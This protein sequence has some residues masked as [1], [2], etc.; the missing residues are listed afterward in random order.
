MGRELQKKKRRSLR[1]PVRPKKPAKK[2]LN[3]RGN[4]IVAK[5]WDKTQTLAQNYRRL[6]LVAR[7]KAPTGGIEKKLGD[8]ATTSAAARARSQ[9]P[10]AIAP[11]ERAVISEAQVERDADGNIVRVLGRGGAD[12]DNPLNDPLRALDSDSDSDAEQD[13]DDD[14]DDEHG[15]GATVGGSR[16]D[17][18]PRF[19]EWG[20]IAE[21]EALQ[22][23]AAAGDVVRS[24]LEQARN[25]APRKCARSG[26]AHQARVG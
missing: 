21:Q 20:G 8:A 12:D 22:Q 16:V 4:S 24:L 10:F 14:D 13:R 5:N 26:E 6:G 23:G 1:Q 15:S 2:V 18:A 9:D 25:P 17:G 3:P 11:V 7:L 19:E